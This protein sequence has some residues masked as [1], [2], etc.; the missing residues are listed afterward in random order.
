MPF[1]SSSEFFQPLVIS[2][3]PNIQKLSSILARTESNKKMTPPT[4]ATDKSCRNN[5]GKYAERGYKT[6][7]LASKL[8][9]WNEVLKHQNNV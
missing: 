6:Q 2:E 8:Q 7:I 5:S 3:H 1:L 4:K 9:N